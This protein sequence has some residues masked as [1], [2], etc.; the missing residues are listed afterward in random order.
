M[1]EQFYYFQTEEIYIIPT[2]SHIKHFS[3]LTLY[4][5][6][7]CFAITIIRKKVDKKKNPKVSQRMMKEVILSSKCKMQIVSRKHKEK[8]KNRNILTDMW[9]RHALGTCR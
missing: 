5:F 1:R 2:Q 9:K 4:M 3:T 6:D 7:L 8:A